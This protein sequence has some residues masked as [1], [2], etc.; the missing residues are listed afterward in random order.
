MQTRVVV[1]SQP[2]AIEYEGDRGERLTIPFK[3]EAALNLGQ[4]LISAY[5]ALARIEMTEVGRDLTE[6][7]VA[8]TPDLDPHRRALMADSLGDFMQA[9]ANQGIR[10]SIST[11]LAE[12][13]ITFLYQARLR[14]VESLPEALVE[15]EPVSPD[16]PAPEEI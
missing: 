16:N 5:N 14:L 3:P 13:I 1:Q 7:D 10:G 15:D 4:D 11:V 12:T 6:A 2:I 9:V 8:P